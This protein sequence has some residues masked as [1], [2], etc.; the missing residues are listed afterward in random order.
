VSVEVLIPLPETMRPV[1]AVRSTLIQSSL[2]SLRNRG[3]YDRYLKLVDPHLRERIVETIAPEWLD[4]D[5]ARAHYEACEALALG[6]EEVLEIGEGVGERIQGTFIATSV[7]RTRVL[8][9]TPWEPL[10]QQQRLWDRLMTGGGIGLV[11]T[12]PN[13]ARVELCLLPL[14]QYA[15]FRGSFSGTISA[16]IKLG[17]GRN[18]NIRVLPSVRHEQRCV[19]RCSW[20]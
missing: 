14:A 9:L 2:A 10:A 19:F 1:S 7:R 17:A 3:H 4:M 5:V 18:V 11:R 20:Q 13:E 6:Q 16:A 15:F 12:A 8:G